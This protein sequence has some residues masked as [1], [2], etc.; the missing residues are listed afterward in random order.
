MSKIERYLPNNQYQ[1]AMNANA[2]SASNP[3]LTEADFNPATANFG[4]YTQTSSSTPVTNTIVETSL[5]DGGLGTLTVPANGFKAGDSFQ[6]VLSGHISSRNNDT[7]TIR[8]KTQ[9][10]VLLAQTGTVTMPTCTNQHWDLKLN[11]TVRTIG[12][13]TVASIASTLLFTYTKNASNAFEGTNVSIINNTTF[14]TTVD[15]TLI[16]TAQ[17]SA[18]NT[19]NSIYSELFTLYKTY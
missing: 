6:A 15:N 8:I 5:L 7:L 12:V 17:W 13:A 4:L 14:D 18:A 1:A 10:G 2:P 16:V 9:S 11:F 3:F 19:T